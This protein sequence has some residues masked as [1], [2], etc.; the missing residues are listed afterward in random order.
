MCKKQTCG[1]L[2]GLINHPGD[3]VHIMNSLL[4][5]LF[6]NDKCGNQVIEITNYVD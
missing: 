5:L 6:V 3:P 4:V 2:D 1:L